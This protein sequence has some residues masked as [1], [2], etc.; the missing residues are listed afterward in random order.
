MPPPFVINLTNSSSLESSSSSPLLSLSNYSNEIEDIIESD[1]YDTE[2]EEEEECNYKQ[3]IMCIAIRSSSINTA[4]TTI[5]TRIRSKKIVLGIDPGEV[6]IGAAVYNIAKEKVIHL[7]DFDLNVFVPDKKSEERSI[8]CYNPSK[9]VVSNIGVSCVRMMDRHNEIFYPDTVARNAPLHRDEVIIIIE[10]QMNDNP[11]NCCV[12]SSMQSIFT[13]KGYECIIMDPK[14]LNKWFPS[15]F[16]GTSN[17]KPLR[18]SR[19]EKFGNKLLTSSEKTLALKYQK[20]HVLFS[21]NSLTITTT[22]TTK[23]SSTKKDLKPT[24]H[25]LD[26]LF[27]VFACCA[28]HPNINFNVGEHRIGLSSVIQFELNQILL[29]YLKKQEI[30]KKE[31][32]KEKGKTIKK[33]KNKNKKRKG[34]TAAT[35]SR[36]KIKKEKTTTSKPSSYYSSKKRRYNRYNK[37]KNGRGK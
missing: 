36:V 17:N 34:T 18:K 29:E 31:K 6:H 1:E 25:A 5:A 35:T 2:E 32:E 10:K 15:I 19:I 37:K 16:I 14:K 4:T 8:S 9:V 23:K 22:T 24:V 13:M 33:N 11:N 3:D 7:C 30:E 21:D 27:Y 26:A 28:E 20:E 12:L